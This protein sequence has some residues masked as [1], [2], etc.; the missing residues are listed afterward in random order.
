MFRGV[1]KFFMFSGHSPNWRV[2]QNFHSPSKKTA[3]QKYRKCERLK[4]ILARLA[5]GFA[6]LLANPEFHSH[7]T[8]W[9]VV[10]RAPVMLVHLHGSY[11]KPDELR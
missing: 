3:G 2:V 1:N 8:S 6:F 4:Q 11:F 7:L 5:S 9:R 10:I